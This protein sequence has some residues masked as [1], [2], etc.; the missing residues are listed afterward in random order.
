[1][2]CIFVF[3]GGGCCKNSLR[4]LIEIPWVMVTESDMH[5]LGSQLCSEESSAQGWWQISSQ[6]VS[7]TLSRPNLEAHFCCSLDSEADLEASVGHRRPQSNVSMSPLTASA[8]GGLAGSQPG[9]P[10][11]NRSRVLMRGAT[12]MRVCAN[13]FLT[14]HQWLEPVF[15]FPKI[16]PTNIFRLN[17]VSEFP[18]SFCLY[19]FS[20]LCILAFFF[21]HW[22]ANFFNILLACFFLFFTHSF[23]YPALLCVC[24]TIFSWLDSVLCLFSLLSLVI[25][26]RLWQLS[27]PH[28][29]PSVLILSWLHLW[30]VYTATLGLWYK[31]KKNKKTQQSSNSVLHSLTLLTRWTNI[32][33]KGTFFSPPQPLTFYYAPI[34]A[35]RT[36]VESKQNSA[37]LPPQPTKH[38]SCFNKYP[39]S[40][41]ASC[42][43]HVLER[44]PLNLPPRVISN[45]AFTRKLDM[46]FACL[47]IPVSQLHTQWIQIP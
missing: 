34:F 38:Y 41:S 24:P 27:G 33:D 23:Q 7:T 46:D 18:P 19:F 1:M 31:T 17:C 3:W 12:C 37:T 4:L 29:Q 2:I 6:L 9:W 15:F 8:Q 28:R 39:S 47:F 35:V 20:R 32:Q 22:K 13:T 16:W 5:L 44:A 43:L 36:Q 45:L 11:S 42:F 30:S 14:E 40:P 25:C 10:Q 21:L 26:G